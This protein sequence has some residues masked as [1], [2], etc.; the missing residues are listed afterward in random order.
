MIAKPESDSGGDC[1]RRRE[2]RHRA[3]GRR[4]PGRLA[5][6]LRVEPGILTP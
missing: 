3:G 1:G 2:I 6:S 4:R 5:D